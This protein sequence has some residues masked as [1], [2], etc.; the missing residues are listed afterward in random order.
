MANIRLDHFSLDR[1]IFRYI[2]N[3][4]FFHYFVFP[5]AVSEEGQGGFAVQDEP[6]EAPD[7]QTQRGQACG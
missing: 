2:H 6:E 3:L 1:L 4:T 5:P 7:T